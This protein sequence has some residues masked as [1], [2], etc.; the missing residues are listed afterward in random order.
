[1]AGNFTDDSEFLQDFQTSRLS[2]TALYPLGKF[3]GSI[4]FFNNDS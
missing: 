2:F 3:C 1:V 4:K